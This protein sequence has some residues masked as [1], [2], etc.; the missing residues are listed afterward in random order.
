MPGIICEMRIPNSTRLIQR[1][2]NCASAYAAGVEMARLSTTLPSAI[3]RLVPS[4]CPCS[5]SAVA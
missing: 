3:T 2:L 4:A 5:E 1:N